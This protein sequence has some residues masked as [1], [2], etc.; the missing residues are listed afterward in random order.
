M[1]ASVLAF[2]ITLP[3]D[4]T[5]AEAAR[6]ACARRLHLVI[7]ADGQFKLAPFVLPGMQKMF[8][9]DKALRNAA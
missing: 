2:P 7:D 8:A 1:S 4:L 3:D 6:Q 9:L 5:H